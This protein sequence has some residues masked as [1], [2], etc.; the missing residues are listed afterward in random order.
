MFQNINDFFTKRP[1]LNFIMLA[2]IFAAIEGLFSF[3]SK[4][5]CVLHLPMQILMYGSLISR[6][7]Q[8]IT[9]PRAIKKILYII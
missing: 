8:F 1:V 7:K 4:K 3:C 6:A 9:K 2:I 5:K